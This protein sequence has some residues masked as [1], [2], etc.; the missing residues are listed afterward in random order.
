MGDKT[1]AS[2]EWQGI[3]I[4][5]SVER[6]WLNQ[7]VCHLE[8]RA[9]E[10]LP[11]TSTGYRSRFLSDD[12]MAAFNSPEAYVLA[13]LDEAALSKEWQALWEARKQL[14]LF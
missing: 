3:P 10:P 8:V 1:V 6:N 11:I 2:F 5:V 7:D 14:S 9:P 12:A 13:W 4:S